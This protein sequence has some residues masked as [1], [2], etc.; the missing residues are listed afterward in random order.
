MAEHISFRKLLRRFSQ[1]ATVLGVMLI[2]V[3]SVSPLQAQVHGIPPSVT[4]IPNHVPPFLPNA[5]ASVTSLGPYGFCCQRP[6]NIPFRNQAFPNPYN[7]RGFRNNGYGLGYGYAVPYYYAYPADD[8][9]YDG[10]AGLIST[11]AAAGQA[12]L[13]DQTLHVIVDTAPPVAPRDEIVDPQPERPSA[14]AI[15]DAKPGEPTVLVF[16]DGHK[17]EALT[18]PS[19]ARRSTSSTAAP[20]KSRWLTWMCRQPLR[21]T[22]IRVWNS[23]FRRRSR[24]PSLQRAACLYKA[25]PTSRRKH[26]AR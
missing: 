5:T 13:A 3:L 18:T 12:P 14:A 7:R 11:R 20:R 25:P 24:V 10:Q 1:F 15:P 4:S 23:R 26:P 17:Q 16:R 6:S 22:T 9:G 2:G 8:S 21:R 19:R